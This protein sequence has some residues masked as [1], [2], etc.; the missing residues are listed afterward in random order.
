MIVTA[1]LREGQA[2]LEPVT[3]YKTKPPLEPTVG[4]TTNDE[5]TTFPAD[6]VKLDAPLAVRVVELPLQMEEGDA[7]ATMVGV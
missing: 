3:E 5:A 1:L 4:V 2:V 6:Q 7:L